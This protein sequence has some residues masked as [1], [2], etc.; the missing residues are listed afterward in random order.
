MRTIA[1]RVRNLE[2]QFGT[3]AGKEQIVLLVCKPGWG[4]ALDR[5]RCI[6]ILR[7]TGLLPTRPV[8][9]VNLMDV[10]DCLNAEETE[11]FL[12]EHA[13]E[14][15]GFLRSRPLPDQSAQAAPA[16]MK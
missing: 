16:A 14:I 10:P 13:A 3:A 11:M 15:C 5:D 2:K 1:R 9:L 12:R 7:E 6:Q 4:V 8:A